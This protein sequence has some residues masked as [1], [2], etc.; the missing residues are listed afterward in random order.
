LLPREHQ[1]SHEAVPSKS[2]FSRE[3]T[4]Q[5]RWLAGLLFSEQLHPGKAWKHLAEVSGQKKEKNIFL[6]HIR[7]TVSV[8]I[9]IQ[10]MFLQL[11]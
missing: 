3:L 2:Q 6:L 1:K 10:N 9:T 5:E 7:I 11:D 8:L 4:Y